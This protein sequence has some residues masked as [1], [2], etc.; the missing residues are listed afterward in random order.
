MKPQE[1]SADE[2]KE[3]GGAVPH[4]LRVGVELQSRGVGIPM[5]SPFT[6]K[7][8]DGVSETK[9]KKKKDRKKKQET[10][11]ERGKKTGKR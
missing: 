10:Q 4:Q 8:S 7:P 6:A 9:Q 3:R 11:K 1:K 5:Q 2:L